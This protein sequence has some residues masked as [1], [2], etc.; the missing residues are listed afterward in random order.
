[1]SLALRGWTLATTSFLTLAFAPGAWGQAT[2]GNISGRVTDASGAALPGVRVTIRSERTGVGRETTTSPEGEYVLP[3]LAP[4]IYSMT[5]GL[6]GFKTAK[7]TSLTL[8]V[9]QQL[10]N[11]FTL[12]LGD[13]TDVVEVVAQ[14]PLLQT[15]SAATGEVIE[16][17][18]IQD[19][20]LIGRNFLELTRLTA[21]TTA[22]QGGNALNLS[23]NGQREFGNSVLVDGV[24]V[25]GNRSNDAELRP[26]IDAVQEFKIVTSA[27][28]PE[29][30]RAAGGV[31]AIQTRSGS[32]EI[33]GSL[34]AFYR[35]KGTAARSFFATEPPAVNHHNVGAT[36]GGPV[37]RNR[38]FFFAAYEGY[39]YDDQFGYLESVPPRDQLRVLP[40]G[41]IDLSGLVDPWTGRTIPIFD[42]A[43]F[44]TY[45]VPRQF[46]GNVLPANRVSPAGLAVLRELFPAPNRAGTS[47]GWLSN[48]AVNQAFAQDFDTF[49]GRL[50]HSVRDADRLSLI[51]H[52]SR[53]DSTTADRF[54]G[55]IPI[56][57]GGDADSGDR[58]DSSNHSLS[59]TWTHVFRR[60]WVAETRAAYNHFRFNQFSTVPT[61]GLA[62]QLGF[63]NVHIPGIEA[64]DGLPVISLGF[65]GSTGGS[66][67]KPLRVLDRNLQ[68]T[69]SLTA[70]VNR[71]EVKLGADVRRLSTQADFSLFPTGF[72]YFGGPGQSLTADPSFAYFD[73]DA[74]YSNGG[75]DIADLLLGLPVSVTRGLQFTQPTTRSWES[76]IYAQDVWRA[77]RRLTL[78]YGARYEYQ[79]PFGEADDQ[80]A[81]FDRATL[82]LLLAGRGSNSSALVEPD[83]NNIAPRLGLAWQLTDRAVLRGGWGLFYTP[84]NDGRA[85]VLT[86]NYPFA[87][88]EETINSVFGGLPFP[89]VL[90]AG[91][92]RDSTI[93]VPPGDAIP[94][95]EIP[96]AR[97]QSFYFVE[98]SFRTGWAQLFN[99]VL[100]RE[101]SSNLTGELGYVGSIGRDLPYGVG[102][103]NVHDQLSHELGR[104]EAQF[105]QG[106]NEY[107][108]LQVKVTRRFSQGLSLLGAYTLGKASDN[109]PAPFNLG[110]NNQA[111]QDPFN[112][113]AE[114]GPAASDVRHNFVGSF[115]YELPFWREV[116]GVRG[117]LGGWQVNGILNLRSGLPFNVIR[118]ADN[119]VAPGLR[120][121]LVGDPELPRDDRTL[122]RYFNTA[123]FSQQG[124]GPIEPGNAGRN[125]LRG[126]GYSNVD[127]SLFKSFRLTNEVTAQVRVEAFNLTNTPHFANPNAE[128]S[129]GNFGTISNT[130]GNARVM[131]FAVRMFF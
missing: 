110:R 69:T 31:V 103:L 77:T 96:N 58:T 86:K 11:D 26:S 107:H 63:G 66:T 33:H 42:P 21:G 1:M 29:F 88:R 32:N 75:S 129:Q 44:A 113:D 35:P 4:D 39:R 54:A 43:Y 82:S 111:P 120:P 114:W 47:N 36:I 104:L 123:A 68:L 116:T 2:S 49:D 62:D 80:A 115:V 122:E 67:F 64:T 83:R 93:D 92:P 17:R 34:S 128:L 126:P 130:I 28:A 22:G 81:N 102:N 105:A 6:E 41:D 131:Q 85:D 60:G 98:P 119:P 37:R 7:R 16:G 38:T 97:N 87:V 12:E 84:E 57:G 20:P 125:I 15:R 90:D 79:A 59:A 52:G 51:Y 23:V 72:F 117:A 106:R 89:Y 118:N 48:F 18:Q 30:G 55:A 3:N 108:S 100:Q 99:V 101:L 25:T 27:Y 45:F 127:L 78:V 74:F 91:I 10:R 14:A 94:I 61:G 71:H 65:G 112:L 53:A 70:H 76:H 124:L 13:F 95:E 24:E 109:G 46:P 8:S 40:N 56:D 5:A 9:D 50:D 19:L 73:P 121:N